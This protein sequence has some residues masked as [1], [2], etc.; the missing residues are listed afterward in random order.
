[1]KN[2]LILLLCVFCQL[3]IA[4]ET[5]KK[6]HIFFG[7]F[8]GNGSVGF[9][10][11]TKGDVQGSMYIFPEF[12]PAKVG[13]E[14]QV[15]TVRYNAFKDLMEFKDNDNIFEYYP[16]V[17]DKEFLL[18]GINKKYHYLTYQTKD[19]RSNNGYLLELYAGKG[20]RLLKRERIKFVEGQVSKTGYD[21]TIPDK[22]IKEND[23][24]F[25]QFGE[26]QILEIPT[27]RKEF[28]KIFGENESKVNQ[29]IKSEGY[30]FKDEKDIIKIL[31]SL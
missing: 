2:L 20:N 28:L 25:V 15:F 3:T 22:Y 17:N 19:G 26:G 12:S 24:L 29:L 9:A 10:T 1:M 18:V 21:R 16:N 6:Q 30:S 27:S 31:N 11:P 7:T 14:M 8:S 13:G 4:Q 23:V 5:P